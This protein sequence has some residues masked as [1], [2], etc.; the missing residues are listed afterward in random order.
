M[1]TKLLALSGAEIKMQDDGK[2]AFAG[3]ASMF[4]GVDAYGDTI[5]KGAYSNTLKNRERPIRMRWNHWGPVIG[6]WLKLGEDSKGLFVEGELTPGH[7]KATDVYA[8]LKHGA[9][10]GMSIGYRVKA[11]EQTS[12]DRRLLKEIELIEISVV[13]EPADLGA[14]V[15]E[16]KSMIEAAESFKEIESL[17]RDAG[18]FSR[19]DA[20][21]LVAR[22]KALCQSDSDANAKVKSAVLDVF[23]RHGLN[24]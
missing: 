18:G 14:K 3:Y 7:S 8:S 24:A 15:G 22:I 13:E 9:V 4:G 17:L 10:D 2:M 23:E 20:T 16:V 12:E 6:K 5:Q 21:T 11:Y 1:E 19:V